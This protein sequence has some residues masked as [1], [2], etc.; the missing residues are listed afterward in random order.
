[1]WPDRERGTAAGPLAFVG[2]VLSGA[3]EL[4]ISKRE[5]TK[6]CLKTDL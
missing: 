1:M 2:R 4:H 3:A 5:V 6:I